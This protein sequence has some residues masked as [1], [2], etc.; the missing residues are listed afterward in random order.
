MWIDINYA[1]RK[2][3]AGVASVNVAWLIVSFILGTACLDEDFSPLIYCRDSHLD[4][5]L[6]FPF[7]IFY[8]GMMPLALYCAVCWDWSDI[9]YIWRTRPAM[10]NRNSI[11]YY[12]LIWILFILLPA[13]VGHVM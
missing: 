6:C 11:D 2:A 10:N 3:R 12:S 13:A 7:I 1:I 9:Y 4:V 8:V 5:L